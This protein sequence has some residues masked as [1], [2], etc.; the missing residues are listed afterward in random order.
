[1]TSADAG[2]LGLDLAQYAGD[3]DSVPGDESLLAI[4]VGLAREAG[5]LIATRRREGVEISATKSTIVDI[6]TAADREAEL[7]L[8]DRLAS[9]RPHDGF[10]GEE[11]DPSS[12]RTGLTWVID[13]IDGTVNYLYGFPNYAV[14]IAVVSGDPSVEPAA[15]E[16]IAGVVLAPDARELFT[17]VRGRGAKLNGA[18]IAV[19]SGPADLAQT[20]L[21]TGYGYEPERRRLQARIWAA[22]A[23]EVRDLR[24]M[25][26]ASLDLCAVAAGRLD[27]YFEIGLKPWDWAAGALIAREAGARVGGWSIEPEGW[28]M[29]IC[30]HP[31]ITGD[32]QEMLAAHVPAELR[33]PAPEQGS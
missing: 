32:L 8:R 2:R 20:L 6:V 9:L 14:S 25:G 7:L 30:G 16:T 24:R 29:L 5:D 3:P 4:A 10:Y 21:A 11:S 28:G 33:N 1:M 17:A 13:P 15:F 27:A 19:G 26:A 31:R 18:P 22:L 23:G 12:G